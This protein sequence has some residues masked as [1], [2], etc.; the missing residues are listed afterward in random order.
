MPMPPRPSSP[1]PLTHEE[2]LAQARVRLSTVR[3]PTTG[4][5]K[6]HVVW[7][8]DEHDVP[9]GGQQPQPDTIPEH[10]TLE[11]KRQIARE[12]STG[13]AL[14]LDAAIATVRMPSVGLSSLTAL[15]PTSAAERSNSTSTEHEDEPLEFALARQRLSTVGYSDFMKRT[16]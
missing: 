13:E 14:V 10:S 9:A 5:G 8:T 11:P 15:P 16:D 12:K 1:P 3:P 4:D 7:G 2:K 6:T